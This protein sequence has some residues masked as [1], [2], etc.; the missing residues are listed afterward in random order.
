ME[1]EGQNICPTTFA[2][3][4]WHLRGKL[5]V[6]LP[7]YPIYPTIQTGPRTRLLCPEFVPICHG[8][9]ADTF[10]ESLFL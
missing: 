2:T 5:G 3:R 9:E 10:T 7:I 4:V 8:L 1:L 6:N